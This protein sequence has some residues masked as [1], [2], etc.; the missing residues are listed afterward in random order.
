[1]SDNRTTAERDALAAR[2]FP[3]EWAAAAT[4]PG[5]SKKRQQ[6]RRNAEMAQER[7]RL[8]AS[9]ARCAICRSFVASDPPSL[10][11]HGPWCRAE[12]DF[13]GYTAA[14]PDGLCLLFKAEESGNVQS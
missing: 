7:D 2:Y 12:S 6:L 10:R 1:M 14:R 4:K 13:N 9:G 8:R 3:R 5:A 11:G